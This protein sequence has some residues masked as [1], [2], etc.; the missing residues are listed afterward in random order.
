MVSIEHQHFYSSEIIHHYRYYHL[1]PQNFHNAYLIE[2]AQKPKSTLQPPKR[3]Q[4]ESASMSESQLASE[5]L[6][7]DDEP[8][9]HPE[10]E[11]VSSLLPLSDS[12]EESESLPSLDSLEAS[13]SLDSVDEQD[14]SDSEEL[15]DSSESVS[16]NTSVFSVASADDHAPCCA[17]PPPAVPP[18]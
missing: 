8:P 4:E 1:L 2:K 6:D 17:L 3:S 12:S 15:V 7:A 14:S 13:E 18:G 5:K 16:L 11:S 10:V 9:L